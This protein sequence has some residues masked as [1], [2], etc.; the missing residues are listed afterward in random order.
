M[1]SGLQNPVGFFPPMIGASM[2][3]LVHQLAGTG[4]SFFDVNR[5]F[6]QTDEPPCN[7]V[8]G[9]LFLGRALWQ[10]SPQ[11][12]PLCNEHLRR[13]EGGHAAM[14]SPNSVLSTMH[15]QHCRAGMLFAQGFINVHCISCCPTPFATIS[16]LFLGTSGSFP[17][18]SGSL[19][20]TFQTSAD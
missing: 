11:N 9:G 15:T 6:P 16:L 13:R 20:S 12:V 17:T 8:S 18:V 4:T 3:S 10:R 14:L 1:R 19:V 2:H 5:Y 7:A